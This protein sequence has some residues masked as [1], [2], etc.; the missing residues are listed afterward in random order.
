MP[1]TCPTCNAQVP[2]GAAFCPACGSPVLPPPPPPLTAPA[3]QIIGEI[4]Q[5]FVIT[6]GWGPVR[7]AFTDRHVYVMNTGEHSL[8]PRP[9][10]YRDWKSTLPP[11]ARWR[12]VSEPWRAPTDPIR[13]TFG[14]WA[15]A[16]VVAEKEHGIGIDHDC[17]QLGLG[18]WKEG[19]QF[20][21]AGSSPQ[22]FSEGRD[23]WIDFHWRVPGDPEGLTDFLRTMPFAS[24]V[25]KRWVDR[26][27]RPM[28]PPP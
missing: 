15:I 1:L 22:G 19:I 7:I 8:I 24:V 18:V 14:N 9:S 4:P 10:I 25:G 13:W 11:Q 27:H 20:S 2:E 16:S 23:P 17:C 12:S 3:E 5:A 6:L 28:P 21:P 26:F